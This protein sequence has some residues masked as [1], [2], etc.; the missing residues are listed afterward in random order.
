[1]EVCLERIQATSAFH[2]IR[3]AS[4]LRLC[5]KNLRVEAA[6][7]SIEAAVQLSGVTQRMLGSGLLANDSVCAV[8]VIIDGER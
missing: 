5:Q 8:A 2:S 7:A 3:A 4:D 6:V 1:M